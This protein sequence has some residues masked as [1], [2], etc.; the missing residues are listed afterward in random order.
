MFHVKHSIGPP[1]RCSRWPAI[2]SPD[3]PRP[4]RTIVAVSAAHQ[5]SD[6]SELRRRFTSTDGLLLQFE[7]TD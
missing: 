6:T 7:S 5:T 2:A 3:R 4:K 1:P